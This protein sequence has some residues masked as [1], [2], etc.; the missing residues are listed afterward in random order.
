[1]CLRT[2]IEI[3]LA[4]NTG[5]A[6]EVL[7]LK[8]GSIAPTHHLHG[9]EGFLAWGE[10]RGEV[11]DGFHLGIL[12]VA[13]FLA[14]HPYG[15][16]ACGRADMHKDAAALP[17]GRYLKL[18]TIRACVVVLLLNHGWIAGELCGPGIAYILIDAIAITIDLEQS[19]HREEIPGRIVITRG[20]ESLGRKIVVFYKKELPIALKTHVTV[21][22]VLVAEAC[23]PLVLI[24]KERT[25]RLDGVHPIDLG[26]E[27][28]LRLALC[29]RA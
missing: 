22:L 20:I 26:I 27:P 11:E 10:I 16:V 19:G 28:S 5:K 21:T 12:A 8:I 25:A 24:S 7:V 18:A 6:P 14:V 1:M 17:V 9:D 13:H 15:E 4:C 29:L 3:D 23:R 2:G